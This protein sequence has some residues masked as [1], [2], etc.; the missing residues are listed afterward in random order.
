MSF[1]STVVLIAQNAEGVEIEF[2]GE[3]ALFFI[4]EYVLFIDEVSGVVL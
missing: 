4:G 1:A 3:A 2:K